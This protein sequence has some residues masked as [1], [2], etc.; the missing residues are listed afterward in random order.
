MLLKLPDEIFICIT[1]VK[2]ADYC[3]CFRILCPGICGCHIT[4]PA[5]LVLY[6]FAPG[7]NPYQRHYDNNHRY[8]Y[9]QPQAS[10]RFAVAFYI[11][12]FELFSCH[13]CIIEG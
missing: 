4:V 11:L 6:S 9:N 3:Y 1:E 5:L 13:F 12:P 7:Y 8:D 2:S 10:V